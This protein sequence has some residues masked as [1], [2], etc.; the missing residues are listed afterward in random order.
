M[1]AYLLLYENGR[2]L[3]KC[4]RRKKNG[5]PTLGDNARDAAGYDLLKLWRLSAYLDNQGGLS[6]YALEDLASE[7]L[8]ATETC[9]HDT[10]YPDAPKAKVCGA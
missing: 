6:S 8:D 3:V 4:L 1:E 9:P 2:T 5:E 7:V 10:R